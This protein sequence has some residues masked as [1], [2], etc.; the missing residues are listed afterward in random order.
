MSPDPKHSLA[1]RLLTWHSLFKV[2]SVP[3][4]P[5]IGIAIGHVWL[6]PEQFR[7]SSGLIVV[8]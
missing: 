1:I 7:Q 2:N 8:V 6:A 4:G 3:V 5:E